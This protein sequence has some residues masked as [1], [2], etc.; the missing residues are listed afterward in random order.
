[1]DGEVWKP[2]LWLQ[3]WEPFEISAD[4]KHEKAL[5]MVMTTS[6]KTQGVWGQGV[7]NVYFQFTEHHFWS[8]RSSE[9]KVM[10]HMGVLFT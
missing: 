3:Q 10:I 5:M 4:L 7:R 8:F 9:L 6:L 1:M 2:F